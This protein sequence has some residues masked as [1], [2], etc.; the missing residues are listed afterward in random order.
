MYR[1]CVSSHALNMQRIKRCKLK[2]HTFKDYI[3]CT[4]TNSL[5]RDQEF[6]PW[7]TVC[8]ATNSLYCDQLFVPWPTFCTVTNSLYRDQ[9]FVP[10]PTVCTTLLQKENITAGKMTGLCTGWLK[11]YTGFC[12]LHR[13]ET[14]LF[15]Q[16]LQTCCGFG[17]AFHLKGS[18]LELQRQAGK[19]TD[20]S[21][22]CSFHI[23]SQCHVQLSSTIKYLLY[24][25]D[26]PNLNDNTCVV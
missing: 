24:L 19:A 3:V 10:W 20:I 17:I 7:P 23:P 4:V 2:L 9:Q 16:I 1:Q 11:Y 12:C 22:P 26:A 6:V 15:F 14:S 25:I 8:T 21:P 13:Q 5:Y 18:T